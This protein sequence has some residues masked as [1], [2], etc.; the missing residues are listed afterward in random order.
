MSENPAKTRRIFTGTYPV[1][2]DKQ[3]R[4]TMPR[5]WRLSSDDEKTQFYIMPGKY[6]RLQI[7]TEERMGTLY[8]T[9]E[10][11]PLANGD[12]IASFTDIASRIQAVTL[13][14]QGRFALNPDLAAYAGITDKAVFLGSITCGTLVAAKD[15][16][17]HQAPSASSFD[18]IQSYEEAAR[19]ARAGNPQP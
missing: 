10:S 1:G 18:L 11:T 7:I 19:R 9:L 15:A 2:V 5:A 4:L 13:D 14:Q 6:N 16:D 8:D 12:N 17:G 3:R